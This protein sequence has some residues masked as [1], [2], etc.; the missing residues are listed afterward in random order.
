MAAA[1]LRTRVSEA[2]SS[3]VTDV[4]HFT[5]SFVAGS[6]DLGGGAALLPERRADLSQTP[7]YPRENA[8]SLFSRLV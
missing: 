7:A 1:A 4:C 5:A 3:D 6:I 2:F 8:I